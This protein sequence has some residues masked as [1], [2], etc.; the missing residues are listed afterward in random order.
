MAP[1]P[2]IL[3][4]T[5]Q[6]KAGLP[7]SQFHD[8]YNNEH[9][10]LRVRL[11]FFENG[12]RYRASDLEGKDASEAKPEWMAIYDVTDMEEMTKEAY[13]R[14]RGPPSKTPR[15]ADTMAQIHVDRKLYD[16]V[17]SK[18]SKE[19][20]RLEEVENEG[21]ENVM[22]AVFI[23]LQPGE[24][25]EEKLNK[26]YRE[27]HT[28]MMSKVPG[29]LRTRRFVTSSI[30]PQAPAQ[31]LALYDYSPKNGL[32]GAPEL[33]AARTTPWAKEVQSKVVKEMKRRVYNSY[34]T[35]GPAP[36]YFSPKLSNWNSTDPQ[37]AYIT[38]T[39]STSAFNAP[40]GAIE[41]YI[42][43]PDGVNLPYRLEGSADPSAP[44]IVLTNS[45]LVTWGIWD[46]FLS[47][48]FSNPTN[49]KYRV[50][51][52]LTR[53]RSSA[54]GTKP[55]TV[56]VLAS[57]VIAILDALRVNKAAAIIGVSLGGAT[58]L[59]T[60]LKYPDRVASFISCD[61]SSKSPAGNS[62]AWGERIAICE[63]ENAVSISSGETIVGKE[64]ADVTVRRWFVKENHDTPEMERIKEMVETNSLDGFRSSVRA[65][66]E[67]DLKEE[68]KNS[69][70]KGM[71]LV[72][73]GDGVLPGTMK[74]MASA[75]GSSGAEYKVIENAGHLPMVEKPEESASVVTGFL[76]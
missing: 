8:W 52:Y 61:T 70:V 21:Q 3:Y 35:F 63:K 45:I 25:M 33:E 65:L 24:G 19:F 46:N 53:G 13:L 34:Y 55:I 44:L 76:G 11:P 22:V 20:R 1:T 9:G 4:V 29:W 69:K 6:P 39:F 54:C 74:E 68:M 16:L 64:L 56:D 49:Q 23:D 73:G 47:S 51:R 15:E 62:K 50:L 17:E 31:Y 48:F 12:F 41:S 60:A 28:E 18:E 43:T 59:N 37:H 27:E 67:Y 14:L 10:P 26:W 30:D 32:S 42:T 72:G 57:D 38:K 2:G 36:R 75:Y 71:F 66:F 58:T 7:I 40:A 5:M